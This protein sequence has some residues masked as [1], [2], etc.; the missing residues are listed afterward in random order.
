MAKAG[1][2]KKKA[3]GAITV[4]EF[5]LRLATL[6][7][8]A[9]K[10]KRGKGGAKSAAARRR[11]KRLQAQGYKTECCGKAVHKVCSS[12]P[13]HVADLVMAPLGTTHSSD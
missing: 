11:W 10:A 2:A 9:K 13:R 7:K 8:R 5:N 1:K 12:C 6:R 4:D 3:I